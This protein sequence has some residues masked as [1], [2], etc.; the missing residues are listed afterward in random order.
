M[1]APRERLTAAADDITLPLLIVNINLSTFPRRPASAVSQS[2]GVHHA[3]GTT[4][5]NS[6]M[7]WNMPPIAGIDSA[8]SAQ[9]WA[10]AP[11]PQSLMT[12]SIR[13]S[14]LPFFPGRE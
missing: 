1:I 5:L 9:S 3:F 2:T 8:G 13:N 6:T 7:L 11:E 4:I 12:H 14:P 10:R